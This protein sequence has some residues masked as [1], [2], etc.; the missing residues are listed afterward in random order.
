MICFSALWLKLRTAYGTRRRGNSVS[1]QQEGKKKW[2]INEWK[3]RLSQVAG[4]L[5]T[6]FTITCVFHAAARTCVKIYT[7][8]AIWK[9]RA[10]TAIGGVSSLSSSAQASSCRV[11][12]EGDSVCGRTRETR[13]RRVLAAQT[14]ARRFSSRGR[15]RRARFVYPREA[16][17]LRSSRSRANN[18]SPRATE[19][20][21]GWWWSRKRVSVAAA[22]IYFS[23]RFR[24][25]AVYH[26]PPAE[27]GGPAA[28]FSP[29]TYGTTT[30]GGARAFLDAGVCLFWRGRVPVARARTLSPD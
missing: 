18:R 8:I 20:A 21:R 9:S 12:R 30:T 14:R 7:L 13:R 1:R 10:P 26:W 6:V 24:T 28:L 4:C 5:Y 29:R 11:R 22:L 16:S 15:C 3:P 2:K 27:K 17:A 25:H 19:S 23:G